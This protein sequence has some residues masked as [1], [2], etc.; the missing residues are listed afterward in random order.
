MIVMPAHVSHAVKAIK[1]SFK[2]LL[3]MIFTLLTE[4]PHETLTTTKKFLTLYNNCFNLMFETYELSAPSG[5]YP[6]MSARTHSA[7]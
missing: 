1:K 4:S 7:V 3:V 5:I 6:R 2:M